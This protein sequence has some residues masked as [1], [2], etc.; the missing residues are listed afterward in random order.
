MQQENYLGHQWVYRQGDYQQ[1]LWVKSHLSD[2]WAVAGDMKIRYLMSEYM[3][4]RV[5]VVEGY[6]FLAEGKALS[7]HIL[8][9]YSSM[10][11][12]GYVLGLYGLKLPDSWTKR[13]DNANKVYTSHMNDVYIV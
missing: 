4:I 13:V 10:E 7:H 1:A 11:R 12:S 2:G 9:T 8:A 3:G 5:D 6:A